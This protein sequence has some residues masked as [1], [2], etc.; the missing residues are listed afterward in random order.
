MCVR[1][2]LALRLNKFETCFNG[3]SVVNVC[4]KSDIIHEVAFVI[5][6]TNAVSN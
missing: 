5:D 4:I 2:A 6:V 3:Y 1:V